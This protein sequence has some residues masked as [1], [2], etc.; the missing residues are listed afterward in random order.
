[1]KTLRL[2]DT[3]RMDMRRCAYNWL[4][5]YCEQLA[6]TC[7]TVYYFSRTIWIISGE[8]SFQSRQQSN[9]YYLLKGLTR[10]FCNISYGFQDTPFQA[11]KT[12]ILEVRS[13]RFS[14]FFNIQNDYSKK[15][16][17]VPRQYLCGEYTRKTGLTGAHNFKACG[18]KLNCIPAI[19]LRPCMV[20]PYQFY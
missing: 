15:L 14:N 7:S 10:A 5:M 18:E 11:R 13:R 9:L 12:E 19:S 16:S 4:K 3:G 20:P 8:I 2:W 6:R 1:M 17:S